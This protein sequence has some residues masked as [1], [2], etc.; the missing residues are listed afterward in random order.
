MTM[1]NLTGSME[2]KMSERQ[3][4]RWENLNERIAGLEQNGIPGVR[5]FFAT[6]AL[7]VLGHIPYTAEQAAVFA[8]K[9]A[10]AMMNERIK[11]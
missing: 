9:V 11:K 2:K 3:D 7:S 4:Y 6:S 8:Y 1:T 5:D 10:D